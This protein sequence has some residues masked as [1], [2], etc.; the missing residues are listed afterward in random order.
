V[1]SSKPVI[2]ICAVRTGCGKSQT[3][4]RVLDILRAK[5]KKVVSIR[6]PMPYGDLVKQKVQRFADYSDLDK[7]ECTI[8]EREEYEPHIDRKAVIYAGVDYEAILREAEKE[9]VDVII[10]D[11][12]NNDFSFYKT[13][14][15]ITVVDPHRAGHETTYY[16]GFTN[17]MMADVIVI[18]KEETASPEDIDTVRQ[19]IAKHNPDAIVVDGASPITVEGGKASE[20][21]GK[22]VLVV[23]DGPTLTHG[24]MRYGAGW[25]AAKK[26]GAGEIVDPRPYA[27]GSLIATYEKYNH[28]D[29][30]LPAM[31]YGEKQMKEL[32]ETI[33]KADVDLVIIGTPID[34]RRVIDIKKPAVRIGYE[35]QEIGKPDLED[36]IEEFLKKHNI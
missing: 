10:W 32:E 31:G 22:R 28:L 3:T 33:N 24:G 23:E 8:E 35:L 34:L 30:I 7:H 4:R 16:P 17:L 29:Q 14:L 9:D 12:G 15:F 20:I 13:D 19:N 27:V 21:K 1:K 6:H 2:S 25:V 11:G 36:I 26:F 18:N 5:G